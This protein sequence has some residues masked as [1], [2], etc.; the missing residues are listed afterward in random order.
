MDLWL[1][2]PCCGGLPSS[3]RQVSHQV[4]FQKETHAI[5]FAAVKEHNSTAHI[6]GGEKTYFVQP[7]DYREDYDSRDG[8]DNATFV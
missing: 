5:N 4:P 1:C 2:R 3:P 8:D 7:P 6:F